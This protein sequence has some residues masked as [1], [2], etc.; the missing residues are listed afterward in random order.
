MTLRHAYL[1]HENLVRPARAQPELWR[2]V[3]GCIVI[4]AT[5]IMLSTLT[6]FIMWFV[7]QP[8]ATQTTDAAAGQTPLSLLLLLGGFIFLTLGTG[9]AARLLHNRS[10]QSVVGRGQ[11]VIRDFLR[12]FRALVVLGV[13]I[14]LL[15]PYEMG[16]PVTPNLSPVTWV[17]L[18]PLSLLALLIQTSAEEIVFRGYL[19]QQIAAR[20]SSPLIWVGVPSALFAFGH[21]LPSEAGENAYYVAAWAGLFGILMADLTARAGNLGPAIAVHFANNLTA[22]ILVSVPDSLSGLALYTID[23][24]ISDPDALGN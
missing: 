10:L 19:Q 17:L 13:V 9:V 6:S 15:P 21:Y 5:A 4:F 20:F 7:L 3:V 2:V 18:L 16:A 24:D 12:V 22:I 11:V 1:P 14:A 23:I 8:D